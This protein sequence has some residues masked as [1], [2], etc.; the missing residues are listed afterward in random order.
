MP[1]TWTATEIADLFSSIDKDDHA[2]GRATLRQ[3][4][5]LQD[6]GL[7]PSVGARD[8]RGTAQY[9]VVGVYQARLLTVLGRVGYDRDSDFFRATCQKL[10][11]ELPE[12]LRGIQ[13]GERWELRLLFGESHLPGSVKTHVARFVRM[14]E[15]DQ[16]SPIVDGFFREIFRGTVDLNASFAGLPSLGAE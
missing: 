4:R 13:G 7:L 12:A 6:K 3:I 5:N 1:R 2:K 15:H 14:G 8:L 11:T 9:D 10:N 16:T